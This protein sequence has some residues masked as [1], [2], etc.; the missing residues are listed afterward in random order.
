M[1]R[2]R[3]VLLAAVIVPCLALAGALRLRAEDLDVPGLFDSAKASFAEKHYGK[4]WS[5]LQLLVAEVSRFRAEALKE[6]MPK[7]PAGWTAEDAQAG[8]GGGWAWVSLG[9]QVTRRYSKGESSSMEV[10]LTADAPAMLLTGLNMFLTNPAMVPAGSKIVMIKGRRGLLESDKEG[11]S[12]NLQ[13]LLNAP[14]AFLRIEG[15]DIAVGDLADAFP[16]ALDLEAIEKASANCARGARG[17]RGLPAAT[18]PGARHALRAGG[19]AAR[20]R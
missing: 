18:A 14:T 3:L 1:R 2:T 17:G 9:T 13:V 4:C 20:A 7:A 6:V 10:Q 15:N 5:D 12:G 8:N 19:R 16:A 11:K